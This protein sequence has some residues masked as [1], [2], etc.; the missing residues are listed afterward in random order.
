M[1][2]AEAERKIDIYKQLVDNYEQMEKTND[3]IIE[4]LKKKISFL[5]KKLDNSNR[6]LKS[7]FDVLNDHELLNGPLITVYE[8]LKKEV[9]SP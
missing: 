9:K 5:E 4:L 6:M 1:T 7:V 8:S 3:T 2:L